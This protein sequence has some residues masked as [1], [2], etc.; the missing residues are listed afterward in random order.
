MKGAVDNFGK[1]NKSWMYFIFRVLVGLLF[2][3]H[4]AQKLFGM[5][6]GTKV[7]LISLFGLAGIIEFFGGL[8][9]VIGLCTRFVA[10]ISA[11]E[12]GYAYVTVH[13]IKNGFIPIM[14]GGELALLYFA[15]FLVILAYGAGKW[16]ID[17]KFA[18]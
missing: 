16:A 13:W 6:G 12:I 7:E 2:M 9:L 15:S 14:N 1:A 11:V 8:L 5:F 18:K 17:N 10:L 4:G 3:Q